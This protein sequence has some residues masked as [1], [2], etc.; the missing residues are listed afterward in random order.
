M[1][2]YILAEGILLLLFTL[3]LILFFKSRP[4]YAPSI[5]QNN[6]TVP[7]FV[8]SIKRLAKSRNFICLLL[9]SGIAM[10]FLNYLGTMLNQILNV[11]NVT[12]SQFAIIGGIS[13]VCGLIAVVIISI[14]ID[15][16]KKFKPV[17]FIL[18][19]T[20]LVVDILL[21]VL[22]EI[23]FEDSLIVWYILSPIMLMSLI[24]FFCMQNS[25][26]DMKTRENRW[27]LVNYK[28]VL[29]MKLKYLK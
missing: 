14:I 11:Y 7:S 5:S 29:S 23:F 27:K 9:I 25:L 1:F 28:I 4:K 20:A 22:T 6:M 15:K 13:N 12:N 19:I 18:A 3:P 2:N 16:Y 17:F 8:E 21:A 26:V 10:G 24:P